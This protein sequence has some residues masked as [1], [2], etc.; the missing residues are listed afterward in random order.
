MKDRWVTAWLSFDLAAS[1][2]AAMSADEVAAGLLR[3]EPVR[4]AVRRR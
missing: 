1:E 4:Q 3:L 2:A